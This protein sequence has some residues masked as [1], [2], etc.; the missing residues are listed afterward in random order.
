VSSCVPLTDS[1]AVARSKTV[2]FDQLASS[3]DHHSNAAAFRC[4]WKSPAAKRWV[5]GRSRVATPAGRK[6]FGDQHRGIIEI[7]DLDVVRQLQ[8]R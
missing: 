6:P 7:D 3:V 5:T 1:D 4:R 8:A 2:A